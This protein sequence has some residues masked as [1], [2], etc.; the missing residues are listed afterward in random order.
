MFRRNTVEIKEEH[1]PSFGNPL[2]SEKEV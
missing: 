1:I 2:L